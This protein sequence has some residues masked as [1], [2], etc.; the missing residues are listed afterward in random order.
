MAAVLRTATFRI[1]PA[2][3]LLS[4]HL[5]CIQQAAGIQSKALRDLQGIKRPPPYDYRH[6][7]YNVWRSFFDKTTHRIDDNS[8]IILLE[9]PIAAGKSAFGQELAKQLD[10]MFIPE[11]TMDMF[12]VNA[13]G[14]DLRQLDH[15]LPPNIRS[16]DTRNFL[17]NPHD[18]RVAVYQLHM[19]KLKFLK[20]LDALG[21]LLSTGQGVII[22]RSFFSDIIFIE[23][24]YEHKLISKLAY[25]A[26]HE[27]RTYTVE[28]V[29]KPHLVIYLDV[30]VDKVQ[31]KI[32][33]RNIDYEVK[34]ELFK[35]NK[36]LNT[37]EE[38]YKHNFL[39]KISEHCEL[40]VYDWSNGGEAELVVED[41]ERIDF[42]RFEKEDMK[43]K[44]WRL[45]PQEEDWCEE[46]MRYTSYQDEIT[47]LLN[48]PLHYCPEMLISP[49]DSD[50]RERVWLS[51]PGVRYSYGYNK[52]A[53]DANLLFK[54][55]FFF[56]D[57][58]S[59]N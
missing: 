47:H 16:F 19:Y 50:I 54:N 46:R 23:A 22:E 42:D 34:S 2:K 56:T 39:K 21:H 40:L 35:D 58:D 57:R 36:Y 32:K 59:A 10:M 29:L 1:A 48:I 26:L 4:K 24:L 51:A 9:G 38:V 45:M 20:Y 31:E 33:Q 53:G 7:P 8:K 12:Y 30:P 5:P 41:I 25:R 37:I 14:Y 17:Q 28:E 18:R 15:K 52:D 44:A 27:V 13:Y 6:K 11:V 49:E 3:S 55:K 43:L